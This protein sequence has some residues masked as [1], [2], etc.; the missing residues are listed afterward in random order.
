MTAAEAVVLV[1]HQPTDDFGAEKVHH[2]AAARRLALGG[3]TRSNGV[4]TVLTRLIFLIPGYSFC[5]QVLMSEIGGGK[6]GYE[7]PFDAV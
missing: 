3:N 6:G 2:F 5:S 1:D 4:A 7:S